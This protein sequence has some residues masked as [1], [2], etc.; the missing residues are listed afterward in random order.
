MRFD[1]AII[2]TSRHKI[3][4]INMELNKQHLPGMVALLKNSPCLEQLIINIMPSDDSEVRLDLKFISL[5]C[6][7]CAYEPENLSLQQH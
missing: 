5:S 3:L 1:Y 7:M 6:L 2:G 4:K